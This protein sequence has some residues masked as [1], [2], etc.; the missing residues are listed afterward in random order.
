MIADDPKS[1]GKQ[2][3]PPIDQTMVVMALARHLYGE[4]A[5]RRVNMADWNDLIL[6]T[7]LDWLD[8]AFDAYALGARLP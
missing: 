8:T 5:K 3:K 1:W 2:H 4:W 7:R 6:S